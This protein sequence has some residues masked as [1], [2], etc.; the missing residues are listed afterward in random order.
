MQQ[1]IYPSKCL[2]QRDIN[3]PI[4]MFVEENMTQVIPPQRGTWRYS[5]QF[6]IYYVNITQVNPKFNHFHSSRIKTC[7]KKYFLFCYL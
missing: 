4:P 5:R 7:V 1:M 2:F 3:V 6:F